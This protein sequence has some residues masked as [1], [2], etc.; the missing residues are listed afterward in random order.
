MKLSKLALS[1]AVLSAVGA[2]SSFATAYAGTVVSGSGCHVSVGDPSSVQ[3]VWSSGG[4]YNGPKG[5]CTSSTTIVG[6]LKRDIPS[7]GDPIDAK[8]VKFG[9]TAATLP[10][11]PCAAHGRAK[12]YGTTNAGGASLDGRHITVC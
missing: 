11:E 9:K 4:R 10:N 7:S 1:V 3:N 6:E 12:Y 2:G 5:S 8:D